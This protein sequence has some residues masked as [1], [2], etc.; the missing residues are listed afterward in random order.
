MGSLFGKIVITMKN[1]LRKIFTA[2]NFELGLLITILLGTISLAV[3][4]MGWRLL[5]IPIGIIGIVTVGSITNYIMNKLT[6][7]NDNK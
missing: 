6:D 4:V 1:F 5:L 7:L 2:K 3:S